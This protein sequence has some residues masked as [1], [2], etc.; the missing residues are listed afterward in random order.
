MFLSDFAIFNKIATSNRGYPKFRD[1]SD[2]EVDR[3][4]NSSPIIT[5]SSTTYEIDS[6]YKLE[7]DDIELKQNDASKLRSHNNPISNW[8]E[9]PAA[10][11]IVSKTQLTA[12]LNEAVDP[13]K[14]K[15]SG[16]SLMFQEFEAKQAQAGNEKGKIPLIIYLPDCSPLKIV[17]KDTC[18]FK[19]VINIVLATHKEQGIQ[20]PLDYNRPQNYEL[21]IHE[22]DGEPDRDFPP[23]DLTK[24]LK[25]FNL[26]DYC[27]CEIDDF[28]GGGGM[29]GFRD[30]D[31]LP[32]PAPSMIARGGRDRRSM[33]E[34][35]PPP[36][37][38]NE[39]GPLSL[40]RQVS[41][42]QSLT[43]GGRGGEDL[44]SPNQPSEEDNLITIIFPNGNQLDLL[45]EDDTTFIELLPMIVKTHR[46][47]LITDEY[48]FTMNQ[49][50]QNR[51]KLMS[52]NVDMNM[53]VK[54]LGCKTFEIQ[55]KMYADSPKVQLKATPVLT[56]KRE[57]NTSQLH[58]DN[59]V[60]N[61]ATANAYQE[62]NVVKK[63]KFGR[64]QER[65]FGVD[66]K[67]VYNSKRGQYRGGVATGVHRAE[68]DISTIVKNE[69]LASDPKTFRITWLDDKDIYNIE[70]SCETERE[71]AEIVSKIKYI[72]NKL[73][74]KR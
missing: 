26:E 62:W 39:F 19:D 7:V 70:Y 72:L 43:R 69:V 73:R 64:R 31:D 25:N 30:S 50:D 8:K 38:N 6:H 17:A 65:I 51:L 46:I 9:K 40:F 35:A 13:T 44:L 27:L 12:P 66:G 33:T 41:A 3:L 2:P 57:R 74:V 37:A 16:L 53:K 32:M 18:D 28:G 22:G 20:P 1:E 34:E 15:L 59:I 55:K 10:A 36:S 11:P 29:G 4:Y 60:F 48:Q 52:P 58:I 63:N 5:E 24:K 14:P 21:R 45:I 23:L 42:R 49:K 56:N 54:L 71:C 61:E 47:R 68:R 67:K